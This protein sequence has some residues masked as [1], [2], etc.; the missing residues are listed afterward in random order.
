MDRRSYNG[1]VSP[2]LRSAPSAGDAA[3][4]V[5]GD[6]RWTRRFTKD[7]WRFARCGG[8][9]LT[10]LQ[11]LPTPADLARHH[12]ASYRDGRYAT[13]A[14]AE[15]ARAAVAA[16]RFTLVRPLA[17]AGSW[18]DLGCSTGTFLAVLAAA[19]IPAEGVE[20]SSAAAGEARARGCTV[21]AGSV[22]TFEPARRFAAVTAF[23][24]VEHVPDPAALLA[25]VASWLLPGGVLALTL[26][27]A[28][29]WT[30][31]AMGR[32]WFYYTAPDHVHYFTPPTITRLL[33]RAGFTDVHVRPTRKPL[34]LDYAA[35]QLRH[36]VPPLA[37][38]AR[39]LEWIAPAG[40]A[41]P[42]PL[43]EMLVTARPAPTA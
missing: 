38:L 3:C 11:P 32:H 26:P 6:T 27:D 16:H 12:E 36:L 5:C 4:V 22:E 7:G 41:I 15:N 40:R 39:A 42:L 21:H 9:G 20:V 19:G 29:S 37:P 13:F 2:A 24:V 14:R 35:E 31:T 30:A 17:P 43:G 18:L 1:A 23:D 33:A 25:R 28:R 8:C 10:S 34:P